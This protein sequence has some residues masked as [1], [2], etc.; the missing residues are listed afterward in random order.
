MINR[1]L[2]FSSGYLATEFSLSPLGKNTHLA[3]TQTFLQQ[4][5]EEAH[6]IGPR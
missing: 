1:M 4:N 6:P 3:V 5:T 2:V